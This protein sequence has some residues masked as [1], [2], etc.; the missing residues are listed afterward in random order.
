MEISLV[1]CNMTESTTTLVEIVKT[2]EP[3]S[4]YKYPCADANESSY[5]KLNKRYGMIFSD[6]EIGSLYTLAL[7]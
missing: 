6:M 5:E 3:P 4:L 7:L 2:D 1:S